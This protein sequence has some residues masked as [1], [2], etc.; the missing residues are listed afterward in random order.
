[1][2]WLLVWLTSLYSNAGAWHVLLPCIEGWSS[3][4]FEMQ[5]LER[6][7][8]RGKKVQCRIQAKKTGSISG[9]ILNRR[10]KYVAFK[11]IWELKK[12]L[13]RIYDLSTNFLCVGACFSRGLHCLSFYVFSSL[14]T[15]NK[16]LFSVLNF[17]F[18]T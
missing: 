18:C 5:K 4:S 11:I 14:T 13:G 12:L 9:R 17:H 6:K 7:H 16:L 8:L 3:Y 1:M 2:L 10:S 15:S